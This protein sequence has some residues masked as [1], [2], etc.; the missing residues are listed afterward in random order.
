MLPDPGRSWPGGEIGKDD[1]HAG[2]AVLLLLASCVHGSLDVISSF[3]ICSGSPQMPVA[4]EIIHVRSDR[5]IRGKVEMQMRM[6]PILQ[7]EVV[8]YT[9]TPSTTYLEPACILIICVLRPA[10]SALSLTPSPS[11]GCCD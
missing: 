7:A 8:L 6:R 5:E 1:A 3:L 2:E 4:C 10:R 11:C 9:L